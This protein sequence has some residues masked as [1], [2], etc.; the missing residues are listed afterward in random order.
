MTDRHLQSEFCGSNLKRV[1]RL[2]AIVA[3]LIA[4]LNV[5]VVCVIAQD[6]VRPDPKSQTLEIH[7]VDEEGSA[8]EGASL[9]PSHVEYQRNTALYRYS[10]K[11]D[12]VTDAKG[13]GTLVFPLG[14]DGPI[15]R[16]RFDVA[17]D[18]FL[19]QK[20]YAKIEDKLVEITLKLSLIHI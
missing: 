3:L 7:V 2:F 17:H 12:T 6:D 18:S 13:K 15:R 10:D 11:A 1:M 14:R 5:L 8:I 19:G 4:Y 20:I 9:E 16:V